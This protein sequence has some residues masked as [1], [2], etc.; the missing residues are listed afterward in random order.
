MSI[1]LINKINFPNY[2]L[3]I[4]DICK[5][6]NLHYNFYMIILIYLLLKNHLF[7]YQIHQYL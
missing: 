5:E 6:I 3:I 2:F 1:L 7:H 4:F